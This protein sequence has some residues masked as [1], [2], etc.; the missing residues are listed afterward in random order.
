MGS[1]IKVSILSLLNKKLNQLDYFGK[2]SIRNYETKGQFD[3]ALDQVRKELG[4]SLENRLAERREHIAAS[5]QQSTSQQPSG[6]GSL[7]I[8]H[9]NMPGAYTLDRDKVLG[10]VIGA[11]VE[12]SPQLP[13]VT[14]R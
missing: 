2:R 12:N 8:N 1:D 5:R 6:C 11:T 13:P 9:D 4:K 7:V 14:T 10:P 3:K